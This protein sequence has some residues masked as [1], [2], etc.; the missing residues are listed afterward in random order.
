MEKVDAFGRGLMASLNGDESGFLIERDDGCRDDHDHPAHYFK[1]YQDWREYERESLEEVR[2]R[3]LDVGCGAGRHCLHLDEKGHEIVGIDISLLAVEVCRKRG[4]S[5]CLV[6]SGLA[7]PFKESSFDTIL[8]MGNTFGLA[9]TMAKTREMLS[10]FH[11]ATVGAAIV[12]AT[13]R[14]PEETDNPLH[15]RYHER[16]RESGRPIGQVRIRYEYK[17]SVG[18][19]FHY[20]MV[21]P[22]QMRKLGEEAGWSLG[23]VF[24]EDSL[25]AAILKRG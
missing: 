6:A 23:K 18:D 4:V 16:N 3:V 11:R 24:K 22:Q 19:W 15:L 1:G 9:G 21:N 20:L 14:V 2:G 17:D 5:R 10:D 8:L 7:L 12:V 13:S 25:Y